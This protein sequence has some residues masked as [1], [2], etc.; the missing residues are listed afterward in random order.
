MIALPALAMLA[1]FVRWHHAIA[2]MVP[3]IL[4]FGFF[5]FA[6]FSENIIRIILVAFY[7]TVRRILS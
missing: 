6:M 7:P 4:A 5:G 1:R 2:G 3:A